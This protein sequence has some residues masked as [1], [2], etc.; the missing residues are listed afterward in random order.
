MPDKGLE[1]FWD[2]LEQAESATDVLNASRENVRKRSLRSAERNV[3]RAI[4]DIDENTNEDS[5]LGKRQRVPAYGKENEQPGFVDAHKVPHVRSQDAEA[6]AAEVEDVVTRED[7][8]DTEIQDEVD[9]S[10]QD[11]VGAQVDD[12]DQ[13]DTQ[14]DCE[15]LLSQRTTESE[16]ELARSVFYLTGNGSVDCSEAL[17]TPWLVNQQDL[18]PKLWQHREAIIAKAQRLESLMGST[19]KLERQGSAVQVDLEKLAM[20]MKDSI[21]DMH[22]QGVGASRIEVVGLVV[23]E[24]RYCGGTFK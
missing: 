8:D 15:E 3:L 21:D 13:E 1:T 17:W 18:A 16:C 4:D 9:G 23:A 11:D 5:R 6:Q 12:V 22:T 10:S 7:H 14:T 2:E 19:E 20:L 24:E